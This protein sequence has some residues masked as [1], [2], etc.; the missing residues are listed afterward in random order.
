MPLGSA[1]NWITVW[2]LGHAVP[3]VWITVSPH[4]HKRTH[5]PWTFPKSPST[6]LFCALT[7]DTFFCT[8][9]S[10]FFISSI[11]QWRQDVKVSW[12]LIEWRNEWRRSVDGAPSLLVP[13]GVTRQPHRDG[14]QMSCCSDSCPNS[15][16]AESAWRIWQRDLSRP[17]HLFQI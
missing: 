12:K 6:L 9:F 14:L 15:G 13:E 3:A 17:P 16:L 7:P 10:H 2:L 1:P 4:E 11:S 5:S 8:R